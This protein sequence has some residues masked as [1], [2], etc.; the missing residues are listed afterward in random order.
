MSY[1]HEDMAHRCH[2]CGRSF[3]AEFVVCHG[4]VGEYELSVMTEV[5]LCECGY[6]YLR[7]ARCFGGSEEAR[8][9]INAAM[10]RELEI[11]VTSRGF[12]WKRPFYMT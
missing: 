6:P 7:G 1:T 2:R 4:D 10:D 12:A 11:A 9:R 3:V 5:G 8:R